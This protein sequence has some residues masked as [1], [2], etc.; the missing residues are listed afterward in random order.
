MLN[1]TPE[2]LADAK[3][4]DL[5]AVSAVIA[6]TE[7][8]VQYHARS[9]ATN[10]GNLDRDL[11]E[12]LA[13]I[14]RIA[15]WEI[16]SRFQGDSV[17]E[18]F[19]FMDRSV[20]GAMDDERRRATRQGVSERA[21]RDFETA[22]SL[23]GGDPYD[24]EKLAQTDAMGA[25][26]MSADLALSA[27]LAWHGS[28]ALDAPRGVEGGTLA[29]TLVADVRD[30]DAD[31]AQERRR[32]TAKAVHRALDKLGT[33]ANHILKGTF[34]IDGPVPFFGEGNDAEFAEYLGVTNV[35][36]RSQRRKAKERFRE[37]Y[38]AGAALDTLGLSAK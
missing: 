16:L 26:K 2:Q 3:N 5:A 38:L 33:R 27:R 14:G 17:G 23:A 9:Y 25:R 15:V 20:S 10:A 32:V 6:A 22:L 13:Q 36:L 37:V 21:A 28:L 12:D 31:R 19:S 30:A 11:A 18:F 29:D 24:A 4:N 7:D 8:R 35:G 34:G 1:I